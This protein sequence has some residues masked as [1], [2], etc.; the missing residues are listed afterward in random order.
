MGNSALSM[1][2]TVVDLSVTKTDSISP[3]SV[4]KVRRLLRA[5]T[6]ISA[7]YFTPTFDRT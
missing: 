5:K 1:A 7:L 3:E 6:S 2:L 4:R